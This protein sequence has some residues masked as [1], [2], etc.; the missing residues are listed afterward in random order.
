MPRKVHEG[1]AMGTAQRMVPEQPPEWEPRP[2]PGSWWQTCQEREA[3]A[4]R[5]LTAFTGPVAGRGRDQ[6]RRRGLTK[7]LDWLQCQ[8]GE[9]WQ[10][11]W[12]ASGADAAGLPV[13]D[14]AASRA[15]AGRG[16]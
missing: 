6:T 4:G 16:P 8:P 9:T 15:D 11:R 7:L 1:P 2:L 10:D 3:L 12:L 14:A 5:L 13:A